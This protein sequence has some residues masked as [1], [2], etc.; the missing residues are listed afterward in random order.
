MWNNWFRIQ[1]RSKWYCIQ[2]T[3]CYSSCT[4]ALLYTAVHSW[5]RVWSVRAYSSVVVT[6]A[7]R[8]LTLNCKRLSAANR[9]V[10]RKNMTFTFVRR[11]PQKRKQKW[12]MV[13]VCCNQSNGNSQRIRLVVWAHTKQCVGN[14]NRWFRIHWVGLYENVQSTRVAAVSGAKIDIREA[15]LL[16]ITYAIWLKPTYVDS[17]ISLSAWAGCVLCYGMNKWHL[18]HRNWM[19]LVAVEVAGRGVR[20]CARAWTHLL[21]W[22]VAG[23]QWLV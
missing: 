23:A 10:C 21:W 20:V 7:H 2:Y 16:A 22:S 17:P 13:C 14:T 4:Y 12:W 8:W 19:D 11:A 6:P 1:M 3:A 9:R 18:S 15:I 5:I